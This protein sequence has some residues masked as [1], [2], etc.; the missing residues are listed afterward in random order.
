MVTALVKPGEEIKASI[1]PVQCDLVHMAMGV[2]GEAGELLDA[3]RKHAIDGEELDIENMKEELGDLE[4]YMERIRQIYNLSR[5]DVASSIASAPDNLL[6]MAIGV[7]IKSGDLLDAIKKHVMYNKEIALDNL[8][9]G[10][11]GIDFYMDLIRKSC[12]F[13]REEIL[14]GNISKLLTSE[15]A[16]YKMGKY[17]DEAAQ[18]RADKE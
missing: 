11:C 9:E 3:V 17:T 15:K 18:K 2:S 6:H 16:R 12:N 7:S 8:K 10:L 1:T 13:S 14:E 5:E 4:F